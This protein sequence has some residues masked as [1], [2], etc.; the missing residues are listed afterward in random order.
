MI[1]LPRNGLM[2]TRKRK[3]YKFAHF[4]AWPNCFSYNDKKPTMATRTK[5]NAY[6]QGDTLQIKPLVLEIAAGTALFSVEMARR[7]PEKNFIAIDVKSDRLYTGAKKAQEEALSNVAFLRMHL[8]EVEQFFKD[9]SV[10]TIWLTFPDPYHRKRSAKHRLTHTS[11]LRQYRNIL[12][13]NGD[14]KFKTDNRDLFLW[15]LEQFVREKWHIQELSFDLHESSLPEDYK[16]MTS[17][18]KRF[19]AQGVPI[20]LVSLT[21]A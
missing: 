4:D 12:G 3:L 1:E 20:N 10:E 5:L 14:L 21:A 13:V 15:S 9:I 18:E 8:N 17:Y 7:H 19:S 6:L 16:I 11:Y 2:L